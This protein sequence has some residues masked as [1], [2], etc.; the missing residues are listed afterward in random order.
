VV[1][2]DNAFRLLQSTD[3]NFNLGA[4]SFGGTE[5]SSRFSSVQ[6]V[7]D[8]I[9]P[10]LKDYI[11]KISL[12]SNSETSETILKILS[13]GDTTECLIPILPRS[14]SLNLKISDA[15]WILYGNFS[16]NSPSSINVPADTKLP[17]LQIGLEQGG[18]EDTY[19]YFIDFML[20]TEYKELKLL[21]SWKHLSA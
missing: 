11:S 2:F 14:V 12:T 19:T 5:D 21:V 1:Q 20:D 8:D 10:K 17:S 7:L 9:P 15:E 16:E 6:C 13:Q 4:H 18:G 3:D